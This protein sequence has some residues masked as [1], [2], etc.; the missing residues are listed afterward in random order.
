M[1]TALLKGLDYWLSHDFQNPNWWWNKIGVPRAMSSLL[2]MLDND[3]SDQQRTRG[4]K[5]V[6]RATIGMTGQNLVWVTETTAIR[7]ILENDEDLVRK[8]YRRIAQE[9]Q[10]TE[11]EGIQADSSFHQHGPC[12]YN[13]GYGAAFV[14]DC[15]H[16]AVAVRGTNMAFPEPILRTLS[17]LILDGSQWMARG[18]ATD[19]GAEGRELTRRNQDARYLSRAATAMLQV[20]DERSDEF[21]ALQDRALG[22][23]A[24]PLEG[25]RH[26]WR[27]D[28]MTHHRKGFYASARMVSQ[29]IAN[30]DGPAN[31]E[32]LK[33]HHL[34]D[35]CQ[36]TM[37]TGREYAGIFPVWNWQTIPGT[38]AVQIPKLQGSPRHNGSR[39]FVGG[40]SDGAYGLAAMDFAYK[41]LEARKSWFFFDEQ[42][43]CLGAGISCSDPEHAVVTTLNQCLLN[44]N[45]FVSDG[46]LVQKIDRGT[47]TIPAPAW[48]WHDRI[49]YLFLDRTGVNLRND[50]QS[51]SWHLINQ[52]AS[53]QQVTRDVFLA[54]IDHGMRPTNA[55]YAYAVLPAISLKQLTATYD[56]PVR[57]VANTRSQQAVWNERLRIGGVAFY[58]A[59]QC[60][61]QPDTVVQVD[62][63]CLLLVRKEKDTYA[64]SIANPENKPARVTVDLQITDS[65]TRTSAANVH[66]WHHVVQ[67]PD[68]LDAGKTVTLEPFKVK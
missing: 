42:I 27:S 41:Q 36:I 65:T 34:A 57:I 45:V 38:T 13:H 56:V 15:S 52:R 21:Q 54:T 5:I 32:G 7:A 61:L 43:V 19:F 11:S 63:P 48:I 2:L 18:S 12:L 62:R 31:G 29:R 24:P 1:H 60:T 16:L 50:A 66:K 4:L 53:S 47:R 68:G 64:I 46:R 30:T 59:G 26:F 3:L 20:T 9:I 35:G 49:A 39:T 37:Q 25:N 40:V 33:S 22:R 44:G 23:P 14:S 51:G 17:S 28:F 10:V 58:A 55:S 67:L 6:S 8:A